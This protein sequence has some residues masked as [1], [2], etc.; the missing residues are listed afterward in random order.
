MNKKHTF[1][2]TTA[3]L[4]GIALSVGATGCSF[5][6]TDNQKDLQQTVATVNISGQLSDE[7][8]DVAK[9]VEAVLAYISKDIMKRDLISSY[10]STGYQYVDSYGYT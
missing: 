1:K 10:L 4:L 2:K 8:K 5:I 7:Y 6:T 3:L 9:D